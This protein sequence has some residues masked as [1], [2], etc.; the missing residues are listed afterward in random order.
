MIT[1]DRFIETSDNYDAW[2]AARQ[3]GVT[4]TEVAKAATPAGFREVMANRANPQPVEVNGFMQFGSDNEDWIARVLKRDFDLMPNRWLIAADGIPE[5]MAT[6]DALSLDHTWI[7]EIK[8]GGTAPLK[9]GLLVPPI[10]H[11]RQM[12]WQM[13]CT[14]AQSCVYAF[15]LRGEVNGELVPAWME[16]LTVLV[17]REEEMIAALV[18]VADQLLIDFEGW[19]AA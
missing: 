14:G 7:G 3:R 8:T 16:P 15:L 5:H 4:A 19:E 2:I 10:A 6:L 12:Q 1:A 13:Y 11:R 17:P 9:D 18:K